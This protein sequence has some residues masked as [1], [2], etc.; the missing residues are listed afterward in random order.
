MKLA[1]I[2]ILSVLVFSC[3]SGVSAKKKAEIEFAIKFHST[4]INSVFVQDS[5]MAETDYRI[6]NIRRIPK[7]SIDKYAKTEMK[8]YSNNWNKPYDIKKDRQLTFDK[9]MDYCKANN[10]DP[11]T[12]YKFLE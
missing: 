9:Y 2:T 6:R 3:H 8:V 11:D 4:N 7:D 12:Y 10:L 5:I 1:Y